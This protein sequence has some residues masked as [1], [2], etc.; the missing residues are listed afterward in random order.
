MTE[1]EWRR[2]NLCD[3]IHTRLKTQEQQRSRRKEKLMREKERNRNRYESEGGDT[4]KRRQ[5]VIF[6]FKHSNTHDGLSFL[7]QMAHF[8]QR[9][10]VKINPFH[11]WLYLIISRWLRRER[12]NFILFMSKSERLLRELLSYWPTSRFSLTFTYVLSISRIPL[13]LSLSLSPIE[14]TRAIFLFC[15]R[16]APASYVLECYDD[17]RDST[18]RLKNTQ[19]LMLKDL[20]V[21]P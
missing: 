8:Y 1:G 5:R 20:H 19:C 14:T 17:D 3:H 18:K 21:F 12:E 13:S 4:D 11:V 6:L 7:G 15:H 10:D 16:L 2:R 9:N